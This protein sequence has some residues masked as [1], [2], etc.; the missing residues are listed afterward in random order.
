MDH[1]QGT[2]GTQAKGSINKCPS[3]GA[4]LGAFVSSC[5]S[6]GHEFTDIDANRSITAL[7]ERFEAI[8]REVDDKGIKGKH[9][10]KAIIE[11]RARVIRD[12]PIPN[13][14][15][16]LQQLMFFIQPKIVNSVQPDPN[17]EDWRV[18][19]IEVLNRAKNAYRGDASALAEFDRVEK[20]LDSSVAQDLQMKA[21]RNPLFAAL[22]VGIVAVAAIGFIGS[23][24]Q[25][26]K[27]QAC[28]STYD[29][30]ALAEKGRLEKIEASVDQGYKAKQYA[31]AQ[32]SAGKLTWQLDNGACKVEA[33][34]QARSFW[35][36][37]RVAVLGLIKSAAD[38]AA[39]EASAASDRAAAAASAAADRQSAEKQAEVH[40]ATTIAEIAADKEKA[41]E[42]EKKW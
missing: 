1:T 14:R 4:P 32:A 16:D 33:N 35:D 29:Q 41:R 40:K 30:S 10:L 11:K 19:F 5:N 15:E 27:L 28:E 36:R 9:R 3:C 31:P 38:A 25:E 2:S 6:C 12:F 13:S 21:K 7:A 20:S 37:K 24:M 23:R 42:T 34:E 26:S 39:T 18:K 8:E 22:L 17:I